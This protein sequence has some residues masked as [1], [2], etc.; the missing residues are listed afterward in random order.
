MKQI[1]RVV[2]DKEVR[3][4]FSRLR[5][6]GDLENGQIACTNCC[7]V[8]TDENFCAV[9]RVDN[10]LVFLCHDASCRGLF[11]SPMGDEAAAE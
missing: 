9:G 2:H 1:F 11:P 5:L 4:L 3:D 8:L 7:R 6:L 10:E